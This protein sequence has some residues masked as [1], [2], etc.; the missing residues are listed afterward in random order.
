MS[1]PGHG[2]LVVH[3]HTVNLSRSSIIGK[4]QGLRIANQREGHA[5]TRLGGLHSIRYAGS[6]ELACFTNALC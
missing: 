1:D 2:A 4:I 3:A 5:V 6:T